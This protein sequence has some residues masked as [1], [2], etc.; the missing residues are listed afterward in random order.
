MKKKKTSALISIV[1]TLAVA[2]YPFALSGTAAAA[3]AGKDT[4]VMKPGMLKGTVVNT[5]DRAV[6]ELP[7][8]LLDKDGSTVGKVKTDKSGRFSISDVDEGGYTL[9]LGDDY[10]LKLALT[11]DAEASEMKV[12]VPED[13]NIDPVGGFTITHVLVGGIIVAV[14]VGVGI[15]VSDSSSSSRSTISP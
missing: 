8:E 4:L 3:P 1:L 9:S 2:L 5:A 15:A 10:S 7:M 6:A 13:D 12:V 14:V 11:S